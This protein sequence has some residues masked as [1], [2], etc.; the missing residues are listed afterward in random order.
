VRRF[1]KGEGGAVSEFSTRLCGSSDLYEP[2]GRRPHASINFVTCHDGF[3]LDDL[4]SYSQKHNEANKEN[5][6]DGENNNNSANYGVEGPT[7]DPKVRALRA[8]Q[9]RNFM[10]T[11]LLS[12]GVPMIL[13]GDEIGRTQQGN[14]NAYCQDNELS[15]FNWELTPEKKEFFDFTKKLI[16]FWKEQPVLQR[17]KFFQGRPI[18]GSGVKDLT[19]FDASGKEMTDEAWNA[20]SVHAVVVRLAGELLDELD[21]RGQ[22]VTGDTLLLLMNAYQEPIP[23]ALPPEQEG[24]EWK[25][26]FDTSDLKRSGE[27]APVKGI[28]ALDGPAVAVFKLSKRQSRRQDDPK[29]A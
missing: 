14:N 7:E 20:P 4:V 25:F 22:K 18:R 16:R 15:W 2:D 9:K 27:T 26:V 8:K 17:R 19:W 1:W 29:T 6:A 10:A 5:N 13:G 23:F 12:Q 24:N 21:S 11:L 3:T 28:Y